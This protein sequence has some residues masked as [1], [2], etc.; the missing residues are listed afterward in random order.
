MRRYSVFITILVTVLTFLLTSIAFAD[1]GARAQVRASPSWSEILAAYLPDGCDLATGFATQRYTLTLKKN[2]QYAGELGINC[3]IASKGPFGLQ[4]YPSYGTVVDSE[5]F[6]DSQVSIGSLGVGL[7]YLGT[8]KCEGKGIDIGFTCFPLTLGI[9]P[10]LIW[11]EPANRART[12]GVTGFGA[13]DLLRA[14]EH[15]SPK[16]SPPL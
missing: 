14:W 3:T 16:R 15:V 1:E 8:G 5:Y 13:I 10:H 4:L 6:G 12:W 2:G 7:K 11:G 9:A